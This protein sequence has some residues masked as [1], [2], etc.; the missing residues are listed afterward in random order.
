MT[1]TLTPGIAQLALNATDGTLLRRSQ[2]ALFQAVARRPLGGSGLT[3]GSLAP[4]PYVPIPETCTGPDC[5]HFIAPEYTFTSSAPDIGDFVEPE[6]G[7]ESAR[8]VRQGPNGRPIPDSHS[9]VFCAYNAGTTTV[10]ITTGG[11]SYSEQVTVQ[12]GSVQQPC[13]TVPLKNPPATAAS[14]HAPVPPPLPTAPPANSPTPAGA[15][16]P[17]P[18]LAPSATPP[19]LAAPAPARAASP[20][21]PF[22]APAPPLVPLIAL[23]LLP[24]PQVARPIPPSGTSVVTQPAVKEE[25]EDEE[26]V[27]SARNSMVAYD[28]QDRTLAP[29]A[30][31]ALIVIAAGAGTGIRRTRRRSRTQPTLARAGSRAYDRF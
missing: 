2:V 14:T 19:V 4:D 12:P 15:V 31:I 7:S 29:V 13:G 10:S 5:G 16:P 26:A 9:G 30:L 3:E 24:P 27:E 25:E 11:L 21:P 1:V 23:P 20:P 28:P 8:A 6:P 22:L 17:P 18:A